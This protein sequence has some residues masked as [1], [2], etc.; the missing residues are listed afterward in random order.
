[1]IALDAV[2][3]G[4]GGQQLLQ[5]CTWRIGRGERIGL[6]GPNGAGKTTLCRILAGV[7]ETDAG[8]V[9]RDTGVTVG[10]LPQEV[11]TG[12]DRTVLAEALS[13]FDEVWRLEAELESLAARMAG[14]G[15]EPGLIDA[16]GE[17]QHRFEALGGYRLE[18]EAKIILG[19]LG[20]SPDGVHRPLA[21]FSGGWR[22]RAALARLLLLRPD[23]LLLDE[24][25]NHLD[26]ESLGWL[27]NFLAAYEGSV[28]IVSHDRYFL[29]RM[30]TAI[31]ELAGGSVTLYHGDYDHFLVEREA[32][33]ALR[34]AQARNQ[35]KRVA[36]IERFIERFR[37]KASKARQVQSRVKMLDRME[38]IETEATARRI[39]FAF[40]QPPRT[41]RLVARLAGVRKAYGDNVVYAGVD[42]QVERGDRV[43]LVGVNGAGKST[44]LKM[45]AG[46]LPFDAG[47]RVLGSHVEVQYYAQ[48]QLDALDPTR[49]VLEEIELAAPEAQISRLRTILGSFLF[50][51]D[52]VE[53]KVAV[54]SGGEKAR[55][56]LAKMLAR[57]AALLCM[58]E[59]TNHL[60]LA[61]KEVLEEALA[62][63]TGTIVFISHDRYF[64]N[65]IATQVVEVDHG[66]L[67]T[68][69]GTYDDYLA[70]KAQGPA[71]PPPADT[72][73][74]TRS[75]A[76]SP[77]PADQANV[78]RSSR[79]SAAGGSAGTTSGPPQRKSLNNETEDTTHSKTADRRKNTKSLDREIKAIKVRLGAVET[80]IHE[81]EARLQEI[82]LALA[83]PD[84][85]RDGD[86]ARDIAQARRDT[87]ER[88]AWLMK[89]WEELSLRLSAVS[90]DA[91]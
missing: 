90:G 87:E 84:L 61:S 45:L 53:K 65:R 7:E 31:A 22:M 76:P 40:P 10:Y 57:P 51:G 42:F 69:L 83:D 50:S 88:V 64:I 63:F 39:H 71:S 41:G 3:K 2:S 6:V 54:L 74:T 5:D 66:R 12:E 59:P 78:R 82:G 15:A 47:E 17:I 27:E 30:V 29:N 52:T 19:G 48:H 43:A 4:Y 46:A 26:L 44:L 72:T 55:L 80:Q 86:R 21:E 23:L 16:Y 28:V 25:T 37:Y 33:Q 32:R 81:M 91:P 67:T 70:H 62:G 77:K 1:M 20:F 35:A 56:A 38:R 58:D 8:R 85:Y 79:V 49:T 9:H 36:E 73:E 60:D 75:T 18:A 24:P 11:T 68:H 14:P 34:E 13:G 89:E